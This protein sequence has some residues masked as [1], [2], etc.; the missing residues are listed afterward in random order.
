MS[1]EI[2]ENIQKNTLIELFQDEEKL[3]S[4]VSKSFFLYEQIVDATIL[5]TS[6]NSRL[7][8]K[9]RKRHILMSFPRDKKG[10]KKTN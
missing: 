2:N 4:L 8:N 9:G 1:L 3:R 6:M 10:R 7:N 5:A